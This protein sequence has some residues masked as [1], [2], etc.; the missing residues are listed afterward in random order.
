M[1]AWS[2]LQLHEGMDPVSNL[3]VSLGGM[4]ERTSGRQL[5]QAV[6]IGLISLRSSG[7]HPVLR[8][9]LLQ[10]NFGGRFAAEAAISNMRVSISAE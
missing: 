2:L 6:V 1:L 5:V 10:R 3:L 7:Q 9:H 4:G 8:T